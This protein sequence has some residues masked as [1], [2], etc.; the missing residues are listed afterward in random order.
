MAA[1]HPLLEAYLEI[2]VRAVP[3]PAEILGCCIGKRAVE[4]VRRRGRDNVC[5]CGRYT[6]FPGLNERPE[7][8]LHVHTIMGNIIQP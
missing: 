4:R 1:G 3:V 2:D 6:S 5:V 7:G 8:H